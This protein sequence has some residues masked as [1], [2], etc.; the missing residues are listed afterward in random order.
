MPATDATESCSDT[1]KICSGRAIK[2]TSAAAAMVGPG[3]AARP[4]SNAVIPSANMSAE[5]SVAT[6][7]PVRRVK[8]PIAGSDAAA[9]SA[10]GST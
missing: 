8:N 1:S 6:A 3:A 10:R 7:S 9:A 5:R 4:T 2:R